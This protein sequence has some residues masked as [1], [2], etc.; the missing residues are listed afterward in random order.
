MRRR[1]SFGLDSWRALRTGSRIRRL[2]RKRRGEEG[3]R[4]AGDEAHFIAAKWRPAARGDGAR[5]CSIVLCIAS[6]F[7]TPPRH[8]ETVSRPPS[9]QCKTAATAR[10]AQLFVSDRWRLAAATVAVSA[11]RVTVTTRPPSGGAL[12][13]T[14]P[15]CTS[16]TERTIERPRPKPP[17]TAAQAAERLGQGLRLR[18]I[19]HRTAIADRQLRAIACGARGDAQVAAG[20]V[21]ADAVLDQVGEHS[22][23]QPWLAAGDRRLKVG[24]DLDPGALGAARAGR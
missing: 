10:R 1:L 11:G 2:T 9:D 23:E 7:G 24:V 6:C 18:R 21:V 3:P 17:L 20:L 14:V 8:G 5:G 4:P 12:S 22:L 16:A 13:S 15:P 19:D